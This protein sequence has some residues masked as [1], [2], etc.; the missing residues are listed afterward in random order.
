MATNTT[1]I[2]RGNILSKDELFYAVMECFEDKILLCKLPENINVSK[3]VI[4]EALNERLESFLISVEDSTFNLSNMKFPMEENFQ[5]ETFLEK[6]SF[7]ANT[8]ISY[9]ENLYLVLRDQVAHVIKAYPL[10]SESETKAPV[11]ILETGENYFIS[12]V[13]VRFLHNEISVTNKTLTSVSKIEL[14]SKQII[15]PGSVYSSNEDRVLVVKETEQELFVKKVSPTALQR[16]HQICAFRVQTVRMLKSELG[17]QVNICEHFENILQQFNAAQKLKEVAKNVILGK[18]SVVRDEDY[19]FYL[20]TSSQFQ[21]K[22]ASGVS[23]SFIAL[24]LTSEPEE[25]SLPVQLREGIT[26]YTNFK[27]VVIKAR[28]L[29]FFSEINSEEIDKL[30]FLIKLKLQKLVKEKETLLL[31]RS[32]AGLFTKQE[33]FVENLKDDT[34]KA[35]LLNGSS[36]SQLNFQYEDESFVKFTFNSIIF[37]FEKDLIC[38]SDKVL[39]DDS[40]DFAKKQLL[41]IYPWDVITTSKVIP[42]KTYALEN[43][44]KNL[45][46]TNFTNNSVTGF[47]TSNSV[48]KEKVGRSVLLPNTSPKTYV[49]NSLVTVDSET[50]LKRTGEFSEFLPEIF[51]RQGFPAFSEGLHFRGTYA[52]TDKGFVLLWDAMFERRDGETKLVRTFFNLDTK[53]SQGATLVSGVN[54]VSKDFYCNYIQHTSNI[55]IQKVCGILSDNELLAFSKNLKLKREEAFLKSPRLYWV[56]IRFSSGDIKIRPVFPISCDDGLVTALTLSKTR[57]VKAAN[58]DYRTSENAFINPT[59]VKLDLNIDAYK[60]GAFLNAPERELMIELQ[61]KVQTMSCEEANV[62][63]SWQRKVHTLLN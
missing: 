37:D 34:N 14:F 30:H 31:L 17:L 41:N 21:L 36:R 3:N 13:S 63:A 54:G 25:V 52:R 58:W 20:L 24:P 2:K 43:K 8:I 48:S 9:N 47:Y 61:N 51:A 1:K 39:A 27:T 44:K 62:N 23:P 42:G 56:P 60:E 26:K 5:C 6:T 7:S 19:N 12:N 50:L 32:E 16:E 40:Y 33:I 59:L 4:K 46:V 35:L 29:S 18:G 11:V 57:K 38:S 49:T 28:H 53:K 45:L 15:L 10:T 22:V 55:N